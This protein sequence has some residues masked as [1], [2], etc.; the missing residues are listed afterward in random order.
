MMDKI[1]AFTGHRQIEK[2]HEKNI[3]ALILRAI[4]YAYGE[5]CRIFITGGALG[6]DTSA[7]R[8]VIRFRMS[9]PDMTL[10]LALPCNDQDKSWNDSQRERY[11]HTLREADEIVYVSE[12]YTEDCMKRRNEYLATNADILI[13]YVKRT[14][15]GAAQTV[16]MAEKLSKKVYNIYPALD[17]A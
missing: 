2:S 10:R 16:R 7:A 6:F 13:A 4:E 8:E 1:C 12:E 11:L 17:N 14:R 3:S 9:H 15:S 5:G